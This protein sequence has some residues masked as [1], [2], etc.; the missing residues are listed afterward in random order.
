VRLY[1]PRIDSWM[2]HFAFDGPTIRSRTRIG[3]G[4]ARL[5]AFN[6]SP[7]IELRTALF[8]LGSYPSDEALNLVGRN[9]S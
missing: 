7:R 6:T 4:T 2:E 1:N 5:L 9:A 8:R 3:N